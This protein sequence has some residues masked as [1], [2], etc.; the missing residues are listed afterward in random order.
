MNIQAPPN[1][2]DAH[3]ADLLDGGI[4]DWGGISP[5][6]PDFINPEKPWPHLEQ[7]RQRTNAKGFELRRRLPVYP[8]FVAQA[9][10]QS[11]LLS[12]RLGTAADARGYA[13]E[14]T[15]ERA[16][17]TGQ[18][19][20]TVLTGGT[21]GAKF[22]DGLRRIVRPEELTIIVNTGDDMLWW[23]LYVSPDIDSITYML[24]GKLSQER[25][26]GVKGDTVFLSASHGATGKSRPGFTP[27]IAIWLPTFSAPSCWPMARRSARPRRR[28]RP[29]LESRRVSCR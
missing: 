1:L 17:E 5:L 21:G 11:D 8:E 10:T 27:A 20:I 26:W 13:M 22:V 28:L 23:G 29:G 3:Y 7:L 18:G 9:A 16:L 15:S 24:A 4:N 2:S 6:T 14:K 19:M 25:G 12:D